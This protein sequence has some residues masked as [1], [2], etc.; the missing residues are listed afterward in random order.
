MAPAAIAAVVRIWQQQTWDLGQR[1]EVR[2]VL[3]FEN[4]GEVVGVSNPHPHGQVYA[5]NFV[6]ETMETEL[7]A[8][9]RYWQD[10][11]RR[12]FAAIIA[13]EQQ[14]GRRILFED[15]HSIAFVLF[16][17]LPGARGQGPGGLH[18]STCSARGEP[19]PKTRDTA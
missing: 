18:R 17:D 16:P 5:T 10:T 9:E 3:V 15:E 13:A 2:H 14:D 8:A 12:L 7:R 6:F 11:G 4:K 1:P 19:G